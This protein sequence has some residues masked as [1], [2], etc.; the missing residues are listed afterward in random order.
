MLI[1]D[2]DVDVVTISYPFFTLFYFF[3]SYLV[4]LLHNV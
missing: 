3:S 1:V 2:V 4:G